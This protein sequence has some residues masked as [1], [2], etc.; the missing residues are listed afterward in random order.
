MNRVPAMSVIG[1]ATVLS[2]GGDKSIARYAPDVVTARFA[3]SESSVRSIAVEIVREWIVLYGI[4]P[5][6]QANVVWT[7]QSQNG[8]CIAR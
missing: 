4:P 7:A 2:P 3:S 5:F 6:V 1:G 8:I